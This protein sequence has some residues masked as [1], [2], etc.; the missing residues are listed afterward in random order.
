M[1]MKGNI[2][3][4]KSSQLNSAVF[5]LYTRPGAPCSSVPVSWHNVT[6]RIN[7]G[8]DDDGD[9]GDGGDDDASTY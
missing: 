3:R 4:G 5:I 8:G 2:K 9:G 1:E 6:L 7:G